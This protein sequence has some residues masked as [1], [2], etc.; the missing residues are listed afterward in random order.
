MLNKAS[1]FLLVVLALLGQFDDV[2]LASAVYPP[3]SPPASEDEY[4]PTPQGCEQRGFP[5]Q[6]TVDQQPRRANAALLHSRLPC[7]S[8]RRALRIAY[9]FYLLLSLLI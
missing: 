5:E 1:A 2:L 4:L 8:N 6:S 9:P 3:S 7:A